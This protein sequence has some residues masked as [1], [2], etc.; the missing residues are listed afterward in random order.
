MRILAHEVKGHEGSTISVSGWVH[1]IRELGQV[2][3]ILLR[4]RSGIVQLVMDEKPGFT[5]ESVITASGT[6]RKNG[7]APGGFELQVSNIQVLAEAAPDL[8]I[9][10]NQD[11]GNLSLDAIL[12]HRIISLRIPKI[13]NIFKLQAGIVQYFGDHMRGEDFIEI[14]S[15]KLI[16]SGTEGGTGLFTVEY[17]DRKVFLAQSPQFYKQTMV[18]S[19]MER[20]FEIGAAYR[21]EKHETPRHLNEYISLD[22]EMGFID[23]EHD[24]MDLEMRILTSIFNRVREEQQDVLQLFD[25]SVPEES[26]LDNTPRISHDEGKEI[27]SKRTGKRVF[28]INPEG[29]R[30]LCDWAM[31]EYGVELIFV[32]SFPRKKRPFYTYPEGQKTK[33]FDLLFRGLEITT[34]GKRINEYDMLL[35]NLPKFG[36]TE[37]GLSDYCT[38]FKYG[39][40]PHGGFA[41]GLERLTQKILGLANVKEASLFPRDRRRVRP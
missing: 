9:P 13:Q 23:S 32:H 8:P 38:I 11:P 3:F 29:E 28:E 21:A 16:G 7:K 12:D 27:I 10:V 6:V 37:E 40:P 36:L 17:F 41:I 14:K 19:G 30:V 2:N 22:V 18:A 34:G 35:E 24:L 1:R 26:A 20:V 31:E 5:Q 39:C 25:T 15:S 4:D 33:S